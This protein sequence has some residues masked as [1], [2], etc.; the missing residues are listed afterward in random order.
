MVDLALVFEEMLNLTD[1]SERR[2][3][4]TELCNMLKGG[5]RENAQMVGF[6]LDGSAIK[7]AANA[8]TAS[9]FLEHQ[10]LSRARADRVRPPCCLSATDFP[11]FS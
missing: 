10:L 11:R 4:G 3:N 7:T 1:P 8:L 5:Q 6:T 9:L 2:Y